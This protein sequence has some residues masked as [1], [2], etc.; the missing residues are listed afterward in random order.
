MYW[1]SSWSDHDGIPA[2]I[3]ETHVLA[4][5]GANPK[6]GHSRIAQLA[7]PHN[8]FGHLSSFKWWKSS[9]WK[10]TCR[11]PKRA[12]LS[13]GLHQNFQKHH[14]RMCYY[15]NGKEFV[16]PNLLST[17]PYVWCSTGVVDTALVGTESRLHVDQP[18]TMNPA[19]QLLSWLSDQPFKKGLRILNMVFHD[20]RVFAIFLS[21]PA[22]FFLICFLFF[23]PSLEW[24]LLT[25]CF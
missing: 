14:S 8:P 10:T 16:N 21:P 3:L 2:T 25:S 7:S 15:H 11:T 12:P 9:T 1:W 24:G 22:I 19:P 18:F 20:V 23:Q 17:I 6:C 4:I 5:V 13:S